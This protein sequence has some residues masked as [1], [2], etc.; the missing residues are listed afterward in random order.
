MLYVVC[1]M[2]YVLCLLGCRELVQAGL[3]WGGAVLW[4]T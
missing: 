2:L 1:C 3:T 4:D